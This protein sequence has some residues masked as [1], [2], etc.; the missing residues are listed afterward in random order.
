MSKMTDKVEEIEREIN[1]IGRELLN[2]KI[3][4]TFLKE[5]QEIK[6]ALTDQILSKIEKGEDTGELTFMS[7]LGEFKYT[8]TKEG[9][10]PPDNIIK[11]E[12]P[13]S[14]Y[15]LGQTF[16]TIGQT[17]RLIEDESVL[18]KLTE[19]AIEASNIMEETITE[20]KEGKRPP[21]D[22][23]KGEM[24]IRKICHACGKIL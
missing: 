21:D 18:P 17:I 16:A 13:P 22:M 24:N 12:T 11:H 7:P 14:K 6:V 19:L 1:E 23:I 4:N 5:S 3:E 10:K 20:T 15:M 8:I 9:K 2:L